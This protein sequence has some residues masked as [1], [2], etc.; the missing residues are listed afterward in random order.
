M[1]RTL[2]DFEQGPVLHENDFTAVPEQINFQWTSVT[3][4]HT[5]IN[6]CACKGAAVHNGMSALPTD[7]TPSNNTVILG[8]G[9]GAY[10]HPGNKRLRQI[11]KSKMLTYSSLDN[12]LEKAM[13]VMECLETV[14]AASED[15][16]AFVK[17]VNGRY[18]STDERTN[19]EK[20]FTTFRDVCNAQSKKSTRKHAGKTSVQQLHVQKQEQQ[21]HLPCTLRPEPPTMQRQSTLTNEASLGQFLLFPYNNN[22]EDGGNGNDFEESQSSGSACGNFYDIETCSLCSIDDG[23][24]GT[25]DTATSSSRRDEPTR[26]PRRDSYFLDSFAPV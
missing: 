9:K 19:R 13:V 3:S 6:S 12:R 10:N 8:R 5:T 1:N 26:R 25:I 20:I 16:P 24:S 4:T 23:T 21:Q 7:Y 14:R 17:R 18:Y 11:V 22:D 2:K 15:E